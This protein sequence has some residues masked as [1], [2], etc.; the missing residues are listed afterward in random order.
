MASYTPVT[1]TSE[2]VTADLLNTANQWGISADSLDFDL[3]RCDTYWKGTVEE[4]WQ[5]LSE[6]TLLDQTTEVEIRSP[7][8]LL[9]QEYTIT[10]RL[11]EPHPFLNLRLSIATDKTKSKSI[12]IIDPSSKIP[13]KKGVQEWIKEAIIRKQLRHGHL[14][15]IYDAN[16]DKEITRLL[17]KIQKEGSLSD[18]YRLPIGEFFPPV[19]P[20]DDAVIPHFKRLKKENSL[21]EGV[22]PGDLILEY[23]FPKHGRDGRGCSGQHIAVDEPV[24]KYNGVIAIDENTLYAEEDQHSIRYYSKVSGFVERKKGV[25]SISQELQ[26]DR[27][28][29]RQTGSIQSGMEKEVHVKIKHKEHT[30]DAVGTGVNI[31]VQR[32]DVN[33]IVGDNVK[34]QAQEV[35]IGAQTH[36]NAQ[37]SVTEIATIHLHRGDLKA[38]EANID[39]LETGKVEADIV[40]VKKMVGGEIIAREVYIDLLYS[41]GRI[42][43]LESI[44]I[45]KIEGEGNRLVIDP[46]SIDAYHEKIENLQIEIQELT[47]RLQ[48]QS[49]EFT[50]RLVAFKEKQSRIKQFQQRVLEAQKKGTEPMKADVIRLQQYKNDIAGFKEEEEQMKQDDLHLHSL[51]AELDKLF[52][53][54]LHATI[55]HHGVYNG[56]NRV[57]FIDPKNQEEYAVTPKGKFTLIRLI[58]EGEDKRLLLES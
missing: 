37:I 33:G 22:Q 23:I 30:R 57:I 41:N 20:V 14:I 50:A 43:A 25:F 47:S 10:I 46:H 27:A 16:L 26:I 3:V 35:N 12:A 8:F 18:Q 49:K 1:I 28:N 24:V 39:V 44:E 17:F 40:R 29:F 53:A 45:Q 54:D 5:H 13:L 4:E 58:L 31:D 15:G 21:I 32:L 56:S 9:R 19:K 48:Q 6:G 34:I 52:A 42:T 7:L 38:K 36:R 2:N 51:Q 11:A 55:T